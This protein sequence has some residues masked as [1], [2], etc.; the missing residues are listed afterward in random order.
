MAVLC[1]MPNKEIKT[2]RAY[3]LFGLKIASDF[4]A[5]IAIPV[6]VFALLGQWLDDRYNKGPLF[7]IIGFV[8]AALTSAQMIYRKA[9]IY[10]EAYKKMK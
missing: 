4:G 6:V 3:Y 1:F 5:S 10:G 8:V 9:K 7:I 2:D